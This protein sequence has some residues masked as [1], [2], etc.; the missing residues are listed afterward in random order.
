MRS[1]DKDL[2]REGLRCLASNPSRENKMKLI[3]VLR[4]RTTVKE[5]GFSPASQPNR[6]RAFRPGEQSLLPQSAPKKTN[7]VILSEALQQMRPADRRHPARSR[8]TPRFPHS[9]G[10]GGE[11]ISL[12][13]STPSTLTYLD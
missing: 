6:K 9:H 12:L 5:R 10:G 3:P 4:S 2:K 13:N 7:S 11:L 1:A 8:S